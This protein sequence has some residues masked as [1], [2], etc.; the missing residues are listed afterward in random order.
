MSEE[1]EEGVETVKEAYVPGTLYIMQESDYL[2]GEKFD[3]Y[4]IG[5]VRGEKD[6]AAREKEHST[7]NPRRIASVKDIL[8][9][10]VQKLETRLHNEYARHRVSSGEW[11]HLPGDLVR[12]VIA[13]AE[14]LNA[15]LEA[16][17]DVLKASKL[18]EG[19]GS[20][21]ALTLSGDILSISERLSEVLGQSAV[22]T[23]YKKTVDS[24]LKELAQ[25]KD[26]WKHLF[27]VRYYKERNAFS[28]TELK[29]KYKALYEE[30]QRIL[31]VTVNPKFVVEPK[32][33]DESSLLSELGL[34]EPEKLGEDIIGLHQANL[35]H[36]SVDAQLKWEQEILEAQ[37]LT[38][39]TDAQGIEGVLLW[40][41][42]ES[43]NFDKEAFIV[44]HPEEYSDSFKL[45]AAST[46][47]RVAEWA[48]YAR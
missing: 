14:A 29:K 12:E 25:G 32:S 43:K 16:E 33:Y 40:N 8:S 41:I 23:S 2:T 28:A 6:V 18:I 36:W 42:R 9:P 39:A 17:I 24:K 20:N 1:N 26:E 30:Y 37:L 44:D 22:V 7:G 15:E 19:P 31:K 3:Y 27:E 21:P 48:S 47:W 35:A 13:L 46:T 10:A 11:F 5:I 34:V 4:K 38:A 45:R